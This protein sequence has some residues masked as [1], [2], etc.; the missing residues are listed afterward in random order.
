MRGDLGEFGGALRPYRRKPDVREVDLDI[1]NKMWRQRG[2]AIFLAGV[3][4]F[5]W[6]CARVAIA[7]TAVYA[8]IAQIPPGNFLAS[9]CLGAAGG[10]VLS[11]WLLQRFLRFDN[12]L[13]G[14]RHAASFLLL[15]AG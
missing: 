13:E 3:C 2:P 14:V 6:R 1:C 9:S 7:G 11:G 10:A 4:L 5:G 8:V 15:A 12:S